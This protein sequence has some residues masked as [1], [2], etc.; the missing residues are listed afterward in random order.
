MKQINN[1]QAN[2]NQIEKNI[3]NTLSILVR[4]DPFL[5]YE[6]PNIYNIFQELTFSIEKSY[7]KGAL[8][9]SSLD[10]NILLVYNFLRKVDNDYAKDFIKLYKDKKIVFTNKSYVE[11]KGPDDFTIYIE[12]TD[13]LKDALNLVH[14]FMHTRNYSKLAT[15]HA[16]SES[17]SIA[18]EF[19]FLDFL[20]S[21]G[22]SIQDINLIKEQRINKYLSDLDTLKFVLPFY[23]QFQQHKKLPTNLYEEYYQNW[24]NEETFI[25]NKNIL[26]GNKTD[27]NRLTSYKHTL[28]FIYA[29]NLHHKYKNPK[30]LK[31][32]NEV[33]KSEF[34]AKIDDF[35]LGNFT[36]SEIKS[37]LYNEIYKRTPKAPQLVYYD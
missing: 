17:V 1:I 34:S 29:S 4:I 13:T 11:E 6:L 23:I 36:A 30:C 31:N 19:F 35:F 14:E 26:I 5:F 37:N 24:I 18:S 9:H 33:V 15:R 25:Y 21:Q 22:T 8:P 10:T 32:A 27:I 16:F 7:L 28:G 12:K 3:F 20:K 2:H